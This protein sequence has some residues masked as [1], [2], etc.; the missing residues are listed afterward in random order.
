MAPAAIASNTADAYSRLI[1][2]TE[3]FPGKRDSE[4]VALARGADLIVYDATFTEDEIASRAGWGHST[5]QRGIR[6]AEE[7]G[8]KQL[9]LFHHDPAHDDNFLDALAPR[10]PRRARAPSRRVKAKSSISDPSLTN[11]SS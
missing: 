1:C 8:A 4:L 3:G 11:N 10:P 2:D 9:C 7:A 6:L 5:W